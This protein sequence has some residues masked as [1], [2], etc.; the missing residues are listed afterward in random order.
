MSVKIIYKDV[1]TG[2]DKD[3]AITTTP[4]TGFSS[5]SALPFGVDTGA[6]ITTELNNWGLNHDIKARGTQPFAFWSENISNSECTFDYSP[7]IV[8]D[9]D[10]KYTATGL[11]FRF[12]PST[13]D[14]CKQIT[15][16]WYQDGTEKVRGTY[17]P[18]SPVFVLEELVEGFNRVILVFDKTSLPNRRAKLEYIGI[19]VIREF[20]GTELTNI[21]I[22]NEIDLISSSIPINVLDAS[23]HSN[24]DADL[25]FQKKQPVEAY[26][27]NELIGYYYVEKGE[28]TSSQ[29]YTINCQSAIG[30]LDLNE[31]NGGML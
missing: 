16:I 29:N 10:E 30:V 14:Y 11:S 17:Y 1:P 12:S 7:Q 31:Y 21:N 28:R 20:G 23:F 22:I 13:N 25:L 5:P 15:A 27:N 2:A 4:Q 8:I 19:G 24:T 18:T 6:I 26:N 3:A 9:F